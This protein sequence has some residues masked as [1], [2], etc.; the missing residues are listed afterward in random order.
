MGELLRFLRSLVP[1]AEDLRETVWRPAADVYRTPNGWL[2]KL[3][4]AGVPPEEIEVTV[5]GREL[6][7]RG[8]R[9]D[10]LIEGDCRCYQLEIA[11]SRFERRLALPADLDEAHVEAEHYHGLLL[12]RIH[13]EE[14]S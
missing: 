8:R 1:A 13:L 11:Y 12:V 6:C 2:V 5:K 3:D 14:P 7:V 10:W 9:R 4:L